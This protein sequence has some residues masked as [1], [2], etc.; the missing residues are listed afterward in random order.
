[1]SSTN[2]IASIDEEFIVKGAKVI[3]EMPIGARI[4]DGEAELAAGDLLGVYNEGHVELW[5][6]LNAAFADDSELQSL[7]AAEL[8]KE[9]K[10]RKVQI[11][12]Q[13]VQRHLADRNPE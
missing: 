9:R 1:M 3:S 2:T 6:V 8:W 7:Q 4:K 5:G 11:V 12:T 13:M 10:A